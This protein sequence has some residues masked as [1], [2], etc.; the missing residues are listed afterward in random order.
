MLFIYYH[1]CNRCQANTQ[2]DQDIKGPTCL[3]LI[4]SPPLLTG[5]T[6]FLSTMLITCFSEKVEHISI[7]SKI[8]ECCLLLNFL[9]IRSGSVESF[10][11]SQYSVFEMHLLLLGT[12]SL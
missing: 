3:L 1:L 10:V 11:F 4:V 5:S 2:A 12:W 7:C 9:E 8:G 6:T